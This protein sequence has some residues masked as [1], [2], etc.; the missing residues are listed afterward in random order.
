M[1]PLPWI[2]RLSNQIG[3]SLMRSRSE[4]RQLL[5]SV[6]GNLAYLQQK[7]SSES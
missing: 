5:V 6:S 3:R 7:E 4:R 2:Q 1:E